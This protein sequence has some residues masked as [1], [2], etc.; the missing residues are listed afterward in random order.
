MVHGFLLLSLIFTGDQVGTVLAWI[1][2]RYVSASFCS[3]SFM[4]PGRAS[5]FELAQCF[6]EDSA[7]R[8]LSVIRFFFFFFRKFG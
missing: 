6:G 8:F 4:T 3:L 1:P 2:Q 5:V 7:A